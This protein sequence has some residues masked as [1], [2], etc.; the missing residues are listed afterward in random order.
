MNSPFVTVVCY[1]KTKRMNREEAIAFYAEGVLNCDGSEK[2]RYANTL[3]QLCL[4][5]DECSDE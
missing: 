3:A 1:G 2:A 5:E 4:G